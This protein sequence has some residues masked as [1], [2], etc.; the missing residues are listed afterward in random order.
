M[1]TVVKIDPDKEYNKAKQVISELGLG[2][3]MNSQISS[4]DKSVDNLKTV[5]NVL[6][7]RATP[8]KRTKPSRKSNKNKKKAKDSS[9]FGKLPSQK[10]PELEVKENI[11]KIDVPPECSSCHRPMTESGLYK[12]SE[13]LEVIPKQYFIVR[14]KR[15]IYT[16]NCCHGSMSNAPAQAS[17]APCSNYGDSVIIDASLSKYCDLIP[18]ERYCD[19]AARAGLEGLPPNS[20][21]G[22]TH[23]LAAFLLPVYEK[24]KA[25]ILSSRVVLMDETPHRM[26]EGDSTSYWYLWGFL[27]QLGCIFEAHGSRSGDVPLNFLRASKAQYLVTDGYSGYKKA[28]RELAAE[29]QII[30]EVYCNAHAYRYFEEASVTWESEAQ[31]FLETY[32]KIYEI[33]RGAESDGQKRQARE[34]MRLHFASLEEQCEAAKKDAMP[35]SYFAKAIAYFLNHSDG[36]KKCIEDITIP[37]TNNYSE[38]TLRSPVLGRKTWYGTHSKRGARTNAILFSLVESCKINSINPRSYFPWIVERIHNKEDILT[39]YEYAALM[40]SG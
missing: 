27:S 30:E 40:D 5:I 9:D 7:E 6:L 18:M 25:E 15:A 13:K 37:L 28:L 33:E 8:K 4:L 11:I 31:P 32:G 38:R 21:I 20:L 22:V 12:T 10:F 26:L 17:I 36:L 24:I 14:S 34:Q 39:P 1:K 35:N 29:G 2:G 19:I 16:C 3:D 23:M